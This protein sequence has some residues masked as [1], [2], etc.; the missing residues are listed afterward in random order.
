[1]LPVA[2][3]CPLWWVARRTWRLLT[4][5]ALA[6]ALSTGAVSL[7]DGAGTPT[8]D[9]I[10]APVAVHRLP[11][12]P[13]A[14]LNGVTAADRPGATAGIARLEAT[15][16]DWTIAADGAVAAGRAVTVGRA[17]AVDRSTAAGRDLAAYAVPLDAGRRAGPVAL[18]PRVSP[19]AP[20][21]PAG[22]P[23]AVAGSRGP[24]A[25]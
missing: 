12:V 6:V 2:L 13:I 22:R 15:P 4:S 19:V 5:L 1:M 20:F 9:S 23:A 10:V 17:V 16:A 8:A 7:A 18:H 14:D 11:A 24:P 25:A 3:T 21:V